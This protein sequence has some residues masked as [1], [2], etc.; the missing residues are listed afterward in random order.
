MRTSQAGKKP[1]RIGE[2]EQPIERPRAIPG[3]RDREAAGR[4]RERKLP[5]DLSSA[6]PKALVPVRHDRH[7]GEIRSEQTGSDRS[8]RPTTVSR[9]PPASAST[10]M[11]AQ[12]SQGEGHRVEPS[13]DAWDRSAFADHADLQKSVRDHDS[14]NDNSQEEECDVRVHG[15]VRW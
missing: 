15:H 14:A 9:P 2:T 3:E 13:G 4:E 10:A 11:Y 7:D 1:I 6:G 5:P 12:K 8:P